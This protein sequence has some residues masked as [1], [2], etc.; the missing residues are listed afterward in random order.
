MV[1]APGF[2]LKLNQ[3]DIDVIVP[4]I[5]VMVNVQDIGV[6]FSHLVEHAGQGAGPVGQADPQPNDPAV[7]QQPLIDNPAQQGAVYI[8]AA[9]H[10]NNLLIVLDLDGNV[11]RIIE[12][13]TP[14]KY[15]SEFI[16]NG[17]NSS[18]LPLTRG[19][20]YILPADS[21]EYYKKLIKR[22]IIE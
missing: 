20:Y 4:D 19:L 15:T 12:D 21:S 5:P 8:A 11:M 18:R 22:I 9:H 14:G 3:G 7:F 16:F 2:Q 6:E 17:N 13:P 1:V 10:Q